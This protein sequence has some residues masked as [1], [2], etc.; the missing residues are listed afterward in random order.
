MGIGLGVGYITPV[1]TLM[2]WFK[3]NKGLATGIAVMGF[4]AAKAIASPIML[5]LM[6]K[7]SNVNS[8]T[9]IKDCSGLYKMF[10]LLGVVYMCLMF[11]AHILLKKP[12]EENIKSVHE[13]KIRISEVLKKYPIKDSIQE[14]PGNKNDNY[15]K[16]ENQLFSSINNFNNIIYPNNNTSRCIEPY[17]K[18]YVLFKPKFQ[19]NDKSRQKLNITSNSLKRVLDSISKENYCGYRNI[20]NNQLNNTNTLS[21]FRQFENNSINIFKF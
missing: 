19:A 16:T 9:G 4:G 8:D 10:I 17:K 6:N 13:D 15:L 21:D 14:F 5:L 18:K 11:I 2:L 7:L 3:D 20:N 1:K 12:E